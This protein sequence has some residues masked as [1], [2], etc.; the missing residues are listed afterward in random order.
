MDRLGR[1]TNAVLFDITAELDL[2]RR[3][4]DG[5]RG[6]GSFGKIAT[7]PAP[8]IDRA[9]FFEEKLNFFLRPKLR[10]GGSIAHIGYKIGYR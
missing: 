5:P 6:K 7:T 8:E 1:G 10:N 9:L 2:R 3:E 4:N